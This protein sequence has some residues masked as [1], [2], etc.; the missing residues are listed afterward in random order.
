LP[1]SAVLT[2]RLQMGQGVWEGLGSFGWV[3]MGLVMVFLF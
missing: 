2:G 3:G 1:L